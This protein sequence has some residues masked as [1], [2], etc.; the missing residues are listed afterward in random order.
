MDSPSQKA[1]HVCAG[2]EKL[3]ILARLTTG[4]ATGEQLQRECQ[5]LDPIGCIHELEQQ[6][7]DITMHRLHRIGRDGCVTHVGLYV[8]KVSP[9]RRAI[10]LGD[11]PGY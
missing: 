10:L 1:N 3:R 7:H 2:F 8:L 11:T 9:E 5:S 4:P 6:G